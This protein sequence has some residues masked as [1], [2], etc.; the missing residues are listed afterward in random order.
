MEDF[1][2]SPDGRVIVVKFDP[3]ASFFILFPSLQP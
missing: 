2:I 3:P 1:Q